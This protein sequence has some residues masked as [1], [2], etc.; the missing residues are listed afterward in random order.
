MQQN[1]KNFCLLLLSVKPSFYLFN[2][3]NPIVSYAQHGSR[4]CLFLSGEQCPR[5][6]SILTISFELGVLQHQVERKKSFKI[7]FVKHLLW[8]YFRSS[9]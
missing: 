2:P 9:F 7:I 5:C 8:I 1:N 3:F 6:F 4:L